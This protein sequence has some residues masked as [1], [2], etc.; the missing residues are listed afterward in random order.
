MRKASDDGPPTELERFHDNIFGSDYE[1][2]DELADQIIGSH[3]ING[4]E[5]VEDFK[6]RV[7]A[8]LRRDFEATG[9]VNKS[10]EAA[11]LSIRQQQQASKPP[12]VKAESW[13]DSLL[14]GA[15]ASTGRSQVLF[16]FHKQKEGEVSASDKTILDDLER[17][18]EKE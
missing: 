1:V 11:L 4:S 6:L 3:N 18:L 15:A 14:G 8:E 2:D 7:Q 5:L 13:I 12:P 16:S 17:E 10:L 9:K